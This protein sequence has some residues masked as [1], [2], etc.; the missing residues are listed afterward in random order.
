GDRVTGSLTF[1]FTDGSIYED[2]TVFSQRGSLRLL[3]DHLIEKG[4]TFKHPMETILDTSTGQFT[5]HYTDGGSA[6]TINQR[7]DVPAD[8]ANGLL[9]TLVKHIRPSAPQTTVSLVAA[10]PAPRTV[11]LEIIPQGK[12]TLTHGTIKLQT[13]HYVVK[14]KIGGISGL[15]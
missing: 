2:T 11:K 5:V 14:V 7:L 8:V 1:R 9:I 13:I 6:K 12:E 15:L 10:T 3:S 4:A